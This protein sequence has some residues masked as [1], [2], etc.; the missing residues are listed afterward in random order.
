ME[1]LTA[2]AKQF[3]DDLDKKFGE[4][5][6][7][8]PEKLPIVIA[9]FASS[10]NFTARCTSCTSSGPEECQNCR[11]NFEESLEQEYPL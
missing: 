5:W 10:V 4:S 11:K 9:K 7:V 3:I 8:D 1:N 6:S 2:Q